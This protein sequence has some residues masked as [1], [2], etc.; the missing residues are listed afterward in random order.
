M[1]ELELEAAELVLERLLSVDELIHFWNML[2]PT[3]YEHP[4]LEDVAI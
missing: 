2:G 4:S 1:I 3:P